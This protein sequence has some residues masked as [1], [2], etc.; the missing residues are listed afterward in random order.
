M[1]L[2]QIDK[3]EIIA[4]EEWLILQVEVH[5]AKLM[6]KQGVSQRELAKRLDVHESNVS[7]MFMGKNMSL[8]KIAKIFM[9]LDASLQ[10][11]AIPVGFETT[12]EPEPQYKTT[13][14]TSWRPRNL[15]LPTQYGINDP[16]AA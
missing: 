10:V 9:A 4:Q 13:E 8:R 12:I 2:K 15:G 3:N 16:K 11:D 7:Q 14:T 1:D 6:E 5:I